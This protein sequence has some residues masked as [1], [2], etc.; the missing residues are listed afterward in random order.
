MT[1]PIPQPPPAGSTDADLDGVLITDVDDGEA[2]VI[3]RLVAGA[4]DGSPTWAQVLKLAR[5]QLAHTVKGRIKENVN[6]LTLWYY[7]NRTVA[8]WCFIF[9]S[10]ILAGAAATPA[11]GLALIGGKKA[12]VPYI[13]RIDGYKAGHSGMKVGAIVAI[14]GF[15][16]IGFCTSVA[17]STFHLLSGNSTDGASSDAVTVK[18]YP[19]SIISGH[20]NLAY[21]DT[22]APTPTPATADDSCWM[23]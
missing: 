23:G 15:S 18:S 21:A 13:N 7:G 3:A 16:H 12:Y 8:A 4:V 1:E 5:A 2:A 11:A 9:I 14:A 6:P 22:P 20:V 19:V 10:W 17:G